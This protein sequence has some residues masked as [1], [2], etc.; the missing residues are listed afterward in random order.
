MKRLGRVAAEGKMT[1]VAQ[2][3]WQP[4]QSTVSMIAKMLAMLCSIAQ[5]SSSGVPIVNFTEWNC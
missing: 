5:E 3:Q 2:G 4:L 1:T